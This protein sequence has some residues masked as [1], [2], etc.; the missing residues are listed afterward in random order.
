MFDLNSVK[1]ILH[2]FDTNQIMEGGERS[3]G[4]KE[5]KELADCFYCKNFLEKLEEIN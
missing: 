5:F 4:R 3:K 2:S 1:Y